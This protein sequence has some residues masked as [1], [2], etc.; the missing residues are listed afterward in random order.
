MHTEV[1]GLSTQT[2]EYQAEAR[3]RLHLPFDLIS[4][5]DLVLKKTLSIPTFTVEGI[6]LY[7]RTTI[8][9]RNGIIEK[10]FYPVFPPDRNAMEVV[11]W[12]QENTGT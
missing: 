1:Y 12:L 4:D 6:E 3:D 9:A 11:Q 7:K 2:T 8:I 10:V 5:S